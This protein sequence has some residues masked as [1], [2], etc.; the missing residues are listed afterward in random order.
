[1][2]A[3]VEPG[4]TTFDAGT[5]FDD[6]LLL[7]LAI[8]SCSE[9]ANGRGFGPLEETIASLPEAVAPELADGASRNPKTDVYAVAA[10][11]AALSA[12]RELP[13]PF[14]SLVRQGTSM[15]PEHRPG[16]ALMGAELSRAARRLGLHGTP[17]GGQTVIAPVAPFRPETLPASAPT[18]VEPPAGPIA[19]VIEEP[20]AQAPVVEAAPELQ[21]AADAAPVT[22]PVPETEAVPKATPEPEAVPK[23]TPEPEPV[24]EAT[25]EPEPVAEAEPQF[26][27]VTPLFRPVE[28]TVEEPTHFPR[29]ISPM[30]RLA[31]GALCA[32]VAIAGAYGGFKAAN[33]SNEKAETA[34][35]GTSL[36]RSNDET[37]DD[38]TLDAGVPVATDVALSVAHFAQVEG[39]DGQA[40]IKVQVGLSGLFNRSATLPSGP[41]AR[42]A[43][44]TGPLAATWVPAGGTVG[45]PDELPG[46]GLILGTPEQVVMAVPPNPAGFQESFTDS[47]GAQRTSLATT[48]TDTVLEGE[49]LIEPVEGVGDDLVFRVPTGTTV[50]GLVLVDDNGNVLSWVLGTQFPAAESPDAF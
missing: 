49:A 19:S 5:E 26:A 44:A 11:V 20:A 28:P 15:I 36:D 40:E 43:L 12:G 13:K 25:Q 31:V 14:A 41:G 45:E 32:A 37:L 39:P 47:A 23:A 6:Q 16:P 33:R 9:L 17:A 46:A 50:V 48:M 4:R 1:M 21:P 34:V 27:P 18:T 38:T 42:L 10:A 29:R 24:P 7:Q 8:A 30:T 35:E 3:V 2:G 22:Q